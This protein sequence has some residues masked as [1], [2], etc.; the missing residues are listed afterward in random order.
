[1]VRITSAVPRL[2]TTAFL[3]LA[4]VTSA[5]TI[6]VKRPQLIQA[7]IDAAQPGDH[8]VVKAGVYD[9][10]L[11]IKTDGITLTGQK[12]TILVPPTMPIPPAQQN[13]C[14]NTTGS[15]N[16]AGICVQGTD[17][18]LA[19][20]PGFEHQKVTSVGRRVKDVTIT[21][22]EING[23]SGENIA[24]YGAENALVTK[25]K[26]VDGQV[27]GVLAAGCINSDVSDNKILSTGLTPFGFRLIGVCSDNESGA[28]VWTN[29]ID[30]YGIAICIQTNGADIQH[31]HITNSCLGAFVDPG[32]NGAIV[33]HNDI[34]PSN[35]ACATAF[36]I[37]TGIVVSGINTE[38]QFNTIV[39][40]S[41]GAAATPSNVGVGILVSDTPGDPRLATG[42]QIVRNTVK[43]CQ[44]DLA[45][46]STGAGNVFKKN[47]CQTPASLCTN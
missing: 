3:T 9:E 10:Q 35:P 15:D 26:I 36:G 39:G 27:Y 5:S 7:A 19:P 18:Q 12:G 11:T 32:V 47:K 14:F 22:F 24:L 43:D 40:Q 21:G 1:M 2:L 34:G 44:L 38:V 30:N 29:D 31:N 13:L 25:N 33:R 8:I 46:I 28:K 23:F 17:V 42:N 4:A 6:T 16:I 37:S 41:I 45:S 20:F